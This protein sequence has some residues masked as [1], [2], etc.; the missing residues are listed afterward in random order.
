MDTVLPPNPVVPDGSVVVPS[1]WLDV[2]YPVPVVVIPA[3]GSTV[4]DTEPNVIPAVGSIAP[5]P[6]PDETDIAPLVGSAALDA[7]PEAVS[8]DEEISFPDAEPEAVSLDEEL[9]FP[10]AEPEAVSMD[11]ELSFPDAEPVAVSLD[12][13]L[14]FPDAEPEA[15]SFDEELPFSEAEPDAVSFVE[16]SV[17]EDESEI[18]PAVDPVEPASNFTEVSFSASVSSVPDVPMVD[19]ADPVAG[20][21]APVVPIVSLVVPLGAWKDEFGGPGGAGGWYD[22]PLGGGYAE[23]VAGRPSLPTDKRWP[24]TP[25]MSDPTTGT[26]LLRMD[27]CEA[28]PIG[29]ANNPGAT[30][31]IE[32]AIQ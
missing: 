14:S 10:D 21:D 2:P 17:P 15:V 5:P 19:P 22:A 32:S 11:E 26:S 31:A 12:E 25:S 9:S 1:A 7:E 27:P 30:R 24:T 6:V 20:S 13:E 18:S 28:S 23:I 16:L 4:P 8:L 3:V 29:L